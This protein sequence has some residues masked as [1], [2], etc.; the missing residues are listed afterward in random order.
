MGKLK[1]ETVNELDSLYFSYEWT[2]NY[3]FGIFVI[4]GLQM[5]VRILDTLWAGYRQSLVAGMGVSVVG[6]F[7]EK[8]WS[9]IESQIREMKISGIEP[10]DGFDPKDSAVLCVLHLNGANKSDDEMQA[11]NRQFKDTFELQIIGFEALLED[12]LLDP[13]GYQA[14][15]HLSQDGGDAKAYDK[16]LENW[17]KLHGLEIVKTKPKRRG[18]NR[19]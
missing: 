6:L 1:E 3:F 2:A 17:L 9:V 10:P 19:N 8:P 7:Y 11:Y 15:R 18:R 13:D 14:Y 16:I 4:F 12:F 5:P